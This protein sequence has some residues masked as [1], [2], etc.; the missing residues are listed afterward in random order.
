MRARAE[1][2]AHRAVS[3]REDGTV[4]YNEYPPFLPIQNF[5]GGNYANYSSWTPNPSDAF[6]KNA[7]TSTSGAMI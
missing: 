1:S 7:I 3:H 4:G 5:T 6:Y 2:A